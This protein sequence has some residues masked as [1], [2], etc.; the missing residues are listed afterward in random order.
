MLL[1]HPDIPEGRRQAAEAVRAHLVHHRGGAPFLSPSDTLLLVRWLDQDV[2][3]EAMLAAIERCAVSRRKNRARTPFTLT[4]TKRHLGKPPL[5][6][7]DLELPEDGEHPFQP[8][9][10]ALDGVDDGLAKDLAELP[11]TVDGAVQLCAGR[12]EARWQA[13]PE[14]DREARIGRAIG[15]LGDLANLVDEDTLRSLAEE[16]ARHH[17]RE[18]WPR[19]D[20]ATFQ[21]LLG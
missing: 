12:V 20:T 13:L 21:V 6:R 7:V 15:E 4:S 8:V 18:E 17:L 11:P 1:D 5:I 9:L 16:V 14:D 3:V 10:E 19:L 2:S